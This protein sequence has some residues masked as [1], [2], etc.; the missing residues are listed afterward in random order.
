LEER[1]RTRLATEVSAERKLHTLCSILS[2]KDCFRELLTALDETGHGE[3]ARYLRQRQTNAQQKCG[4][5]K[6][7]W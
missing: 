2:F 5:L 6:G 3:A 4:K 1:D 7:E